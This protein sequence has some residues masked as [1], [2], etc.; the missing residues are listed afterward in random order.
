[1]KE[2]PLTISVLKPGSKE[3]IRTGGCSHWFSACL[4]I[5]EIVQFFDD[6]SLENN[7]LSASLSVNAWLDEKLE[8]ETQLWNL[9][10]PP[11][12]PIVTGSNNQLCISSDSNRDIM[13]FERSIPPVVDIL[14]DAPGFADRNVL[15]LTGTLTSSSPLSQ[16][17]QVSVLAEHPKKKGMIAYQ[18]HLGKTDGSERLGCIQ[19]RFDVEVCLEK[20]VEAGFFDHGNVKLFW[21][22]KGSG[23]HS[24]KRLNLDRDR[25]AHFEGHRIQNHVGILPGLGICTY[26][27]RNNLG[28][29][30]ALRSNL[31]EDNIASRMKESLALLLG[32]VLP[33]PRR[34]VWLTYENNCSTAQ[35]NSFYLFKWMCD[36]G[37]PERM[38]FVIRGM[39]TLP[40]ELE[41]YRK[42]TVNYYSFRHLLLMVRATAFVSAQGRHHCYKLRPIY[43]AFTEMVN[44]KQ[45]IFLQH[46]VT[47]FKRSMFHKTDKSGGANLVMCTSENEKKL[48][49]KHWGYRADQVVDAGFSRFDALQDKSISGGQ[50]IVIMPTWRKHLE[51]VSPEA[52][53][54]C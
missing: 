32:R 38:Y 29:Q 3:A 1:M 25:F 5:E 26:V 2:W 14:L 53:Q 27:E 30:L 24:R 41:P 48:I 21:E 9:R 47:A 42:Q 23:F 12:P 43:S 17:L 28:L 46:G 31:P 54:E 49:Q 52:F 7:R 35:D 13:R 33:K 10:C 15:Q 4:P 45:F 19:T 16:E 50:H 39:D 40:K 34:P 20:L 6:L 51:L 37:A 36:N 8:F 44:R 22:I 18:C 11:P